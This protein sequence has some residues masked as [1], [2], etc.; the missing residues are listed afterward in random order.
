LRTTFY[1]LFIL[2]IFVISIML[3]WDYGLSELVGIISSG[4]THQIAEVI[5]NAGST[6]IIIS[7]LINILINILGVLPS[8]FITGANVIVFGIYGG[9]LVSWAGE[10]I[11][12]VISL[13]LYRWGLK[14]AAK[15]P[16][17][18]L[19]LSKFINNLPGVKQ[20]YFLAVLRVAPFIPSGL[21]NLLGAITSVSVA[22]FVIATA[23][24]KI[25]S[26]ALEAAFSYNL[27]NYNTNYG[28]LVITVIV[29]LLL[30]IGIRKELLRL[31][32]RG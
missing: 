20:I 28:N 8:I 15:L 11:G 22:N 18:Q 21:I 30:Y 19:Q 31:K 23:I 6:A 26:L 10:V 24:G 12:A 1:R 27:L 16:T 14:T 5:A 2:F 29:A 4:N 13:I 7:I 3:L 17:D 9:F 25:P 32:V